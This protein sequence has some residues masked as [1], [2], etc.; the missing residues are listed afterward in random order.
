MLAMPSQKANDRMGNRQA[1][2]ARFFHE[3][4]PAECPAMTL[5]AKPRF[6][7]PCNGCGL[8]CAL[9]ICSIGEKVFPGAGA[10]C[11]ALKI[12]EDRRRT[13]CELVAIE[14]IHGLKPI[15]ATALGVGLGCD[16]GDVDT[17][18]AKAALP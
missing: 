15:I 2:N 1:C 3:S 5:P 8:C 7:S 10:P 4:R 12:T 14:K 6:G 11:P 18:L 17:I 9:E 16:A 13:Y